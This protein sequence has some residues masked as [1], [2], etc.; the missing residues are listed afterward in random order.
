MIDFIFKLAE[1]ER[2]ERAR[3]ALLRRGC[4][5]QVERGDS[6]DSGDTVSHSGSSRT[7]ENPTEQ[8]VVIKHQMVPAQPQSQPHPG[9]QRLVPGVKVHMSSHSLHSVHSHHTVHNVGQEDEQNSDDQLSSEDNLSHE[10]Y[11]LL[12][13]EQAAAHPS[14]LGSHQCPHSSYRALCKEWRPVQGTLP[15]GR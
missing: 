8:T 6:V 15:G 14:D 5:G 7:T 2:R 1:R 9:G 13:K 10:S 3:E 12:D 11:D 4:D